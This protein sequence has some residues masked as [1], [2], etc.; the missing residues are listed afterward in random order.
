[1][2]RIFTSKDRELLTFTFGNGSL[3]FI[4]IQY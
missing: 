4:Q 3:V 1:M 2:A